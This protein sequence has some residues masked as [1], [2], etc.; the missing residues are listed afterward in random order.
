MRAIRCASVSRRSMSTIARVAAGACDLFF[1]GRRGIAIVG[2]AIF[3]GSD[4]A[5]WTF[6]GVTMRRCCVRYASVSARGDDVTLPPGTGLPRPWVRSGRITPSCRGITADW[7]S[8]VPHQK[9]PDQTMSTRSRA[10]RRRGVLRLFSARVT[11]FGS[12]LVAVPLLVQMLPLTTVGALH[13]HAGCHC[14][15]GLTGSGLR[16]RARFVG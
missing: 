5:Q 8:A 6:R 11:G 13:C 12:A 7:P 1:T 9:P 4:R 2:D 3:Q 14:R 15:T 10:R 16:G